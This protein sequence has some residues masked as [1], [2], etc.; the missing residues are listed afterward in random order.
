MSSVGADVAWNT[1][2]TQYNTYS[3]DPIVGLAASAA[4]LSFEPVDTD[5]SAYTTNMALNG[6]FNSNS[7]RRSKNK[8]RYY[9]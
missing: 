5:I 3:T 8:N 9:S 6:L 2:T 1:I 7:K 4:G